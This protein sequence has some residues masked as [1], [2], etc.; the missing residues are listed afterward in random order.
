MEG[1]DLHAGEAAV[2]AQLRHLHHA[3]HLLV[4]LV[5]G[6]L[7]GGDVGEI[8]FGQGGAGVVAGVVAAQTQG[9]LLEQLGVIH[10]AAVVEPV[11]LLHVGVLVGQDVVGVAVGIDLV[12]RERGAAQEDQAEAALGTLD[13]VF[14]AQLAVFPVRAS[15][16]VIALAHGCHAETV[17]DGQIADLHGGEQMFKLI[18][19]DNQ[20]LSCVWDR[21]DWDQSKSRTGLMTFCAMSS[22]IACW[23]SSN[24]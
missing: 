11:T 5:N 7:R 24:L 22:A 19:H 16:T 1:V 14:D 20:I 3:V 4:D 15:Q 21:V 12:V 18:C 8:E 9:D 23:M 2:L 10:R 13:D 6:Q 17:L